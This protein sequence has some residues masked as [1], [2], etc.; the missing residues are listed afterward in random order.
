M[1]A[2]GYV[3]IRM[4][5]ASDLPPGPEDR[6]DVAVDSSPIDLGVIQGL[7]D[8]V[9]EVA[10][11]MEVH[12]QLKGTVEEPEP[13]GAITIRDGAMTVAPTGVRYTGISG[14]VDLQPDRVSTDLMTV[15]DNQFSALS[16]TGAV[17]VNART[18][19]EVHLYINARDFKI[20]DNDLGNVRAE[21]A[22]EVNGDLRAPR[23]EG[24]FG[25]STGRVELDEILAA[26]GP[27]PYSTEALG[28]EPSAQVETSNQSLF[29]SA[30]V[31]V[32]VIVPNDLVV[33]ASQLQTDASP[34]GLGALNVTLGGDL[35]ATKSPGG[36]LSLVGDVKTIRGTYDFQGRRL[37]ILRDGSIRFIGLD[38]TNPELNLR[39]QRLIRGVE[40][41]VDILGTLKEPKV[42]LSSVPPLEEA[43]ILSLLVFNMPSNE[44]GTAAQ[45]SLAQRAQAL[46]AG[47]VAS[48][49][50]ESI[51]N[52]LNLDTF[53]INLA[54]EDGGNAQVALGQQ[55]GANVYV[56]VEQGIGDASTTNFIL[57]Y[58]LNDWLR[59]QTNVVEGSSTQQSMFRRAQSTGSDLIFLFSF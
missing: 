44:L 41:H 27:A 51:G 4:F 25:V 12:A 24:Y 6:M 15:L 21:T 54:P 20:I 42:A 23:I 53:E 10:G 11:T 58:E 55:I 2:K 5:R 28:T 7:T 13:S 29:R 34:V 1:T 59:L 40:V 18:V 35:Q 32:H 19:G 57:E 14:Q 3:P 52:A 22:L 9:T 31:N 39:T 43:D 37:E 26:I 56:R 49:L 48:Q 16:V 8:T 33:R 30:T 45:V 36:D 50:A 47:A 38:E 46:A 17:A